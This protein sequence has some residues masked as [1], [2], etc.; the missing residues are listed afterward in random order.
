MSREEIEDLLENFSKIELD[1]F[2]NYDN[3]DMVLFAE[4]ILEK[5][6]LKTDKN[7]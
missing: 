4:H 7:S 3:Y 1:A 6:K 2:D 5:Y